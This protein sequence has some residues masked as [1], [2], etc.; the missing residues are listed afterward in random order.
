[1]PRGIGTSQTQQVI[2]M[3]YQETYDA[4]DLSA[5]VIDFLGQFGVAIIAFVA[6]VG[7]VVLYVWAKRQLAGR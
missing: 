2:R 3:A 4:N 7:L 5:I 1:M 6:L